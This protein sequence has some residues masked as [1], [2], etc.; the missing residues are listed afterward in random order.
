MESAKAEKTSG[1]RAFGMDRTE[2]VG[3]E[4]D[5]LESCFGVGKR[6]RGFCQE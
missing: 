3:G 6:S 2:R 5:R 1:G 4:P